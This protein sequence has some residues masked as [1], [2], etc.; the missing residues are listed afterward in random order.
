M[1]IGQMRIYGC[2]GCGTNIAS[3]FINLPQE[4]FTAQISPVFIDTSRSNLRPDI[5]ED[6]C[7]ILKNLD[8][9]G[10]VRSENYSEITNVVRD[11][12]FKHPP[13]DFSVVVFSGSGGSGSVIGP[14]IAAELLER[15]ATFV[16]V[17]V[18]SDESAISATNTMNTLKSLEGISKKAGKPINMHYRFNTRNHPRTEIDANLIGSIG[19]LAIMASRQISELDRKDISHFLRFDKSTPS[20]IPA[21]L[22]MLEI[23]TDSD[24][25][26]WSEYSPISVV[27]IYQN[28]DEP[29]ISVTP[30][31]SCQC[32]APIK[33]GDV[34]NLHF[35]IDVDIVPRFAAVIQ[36]TLQGLD[37]LRKS[38]PKV[39]N[40]LS[41][42]DTPDDNGMIMS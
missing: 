1:E 19:S 25:P 2:G 10:K 21:R 35:L 27:S 28:P 36:K 3:N 7:Y 41:D 22:A 5:G 20:K 12:L 42:K 23:L 31:Y 37:D 39:A 18:G 40:L 30:E 13:L 38:K 8:G 17:V 9:S 34:R 29:T 4:P 32:Y 6:S 14:L 15:D 26:S 33:L 16:V 11:I 24:G